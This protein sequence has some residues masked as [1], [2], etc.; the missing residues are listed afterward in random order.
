MTRAYLNRIATAVPE[1]DIHRT[2]VHFTERLLRQRRTRL[3]FERMVARS[4]ISHRWSCLSPA[5]DGANEAVDADGFYT[6]GK[7]PTTAERMERY[8]RE[9]PILAVKAVEG[10]GLGDE[11]GQIT[12]LIVT[13]CTGF[14]APGIDFE[15]MR[16]CYLNTSIERTVV[17]F[18]GCNAA[19][20]ALKL[21]RHVVRSTPDSKV[22][23]ICLELCTLHLQDTDNID[24]LLSFLLF[25]DG[26]GAAVVSA[27]PFGFA[28]DGFHAEVTPEAVEQIT[29][30]IRNFG[31]DMILSG[32][33]PKT[34]CKT[35]RSAS[36]RVLAGTP[37]QRIDLWAVHPGGRTVLDAVESAFELDESALTV[38]R[39]IL[40]DYGNMSSPTVLFVLEAI[41]RKKVTA[42]ALGCAIAFGPGLTAETMLFSAAG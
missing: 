35:L 13:S 25:G 39:A 30:T 16:R 11:L 27:A 41:M 14:S 22:L 3:L 10:L 8:E 24:R 7:F 12:H 6:L 42:G 28:I 33:V 18:M 19:I 32:D 4:D 31:F 23:I 20:N 40:R 21:A 9:A 2:F 36:S 1:H 29:W 26:C 34:V 5:R 37:A 15:V 38:S 17:G